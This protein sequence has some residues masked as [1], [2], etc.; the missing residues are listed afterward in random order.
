M[1]S[2]NAQSMKLPGFRYMGFDI[3]GMELSE[4]LVDDLG[5]SEPAYKLAPKSAPLSWK[6]GL[7]MVGRD[8][9]MGSDDAEALPSP[10]KK[11][12]RMVYSN[13]QERKVEGT[14]HK[15]GVLFLPRNQ[16]PKGM[17]QPKDEGYVLARYFKDIEGFDEKDDDWVIKPSYQ[18]E[19][20]LVWVPKGGGSFVVPTMD[21][22]YNPVTG[23]P[24]ETVENRKEA[25]KRWEKAG[26]SP[27]QAEK[28]ISRFY[29]SDSGTRAV[30]SWWSDDDVGPLCVDLS[31]VPWSWDSDVGSFPASW[32]AERSVAPKNPGYRMIT[33]D[34][35]ASFEADR[36]TL[37]TIREAVNK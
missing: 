27:E 1:S 31:G 36:K 21:G 17:L 24:F 10:I 28:E 37:E 11:A 6:V 29:R 33:E 12:G 5:T 8:L 9:E 26:L 4:A 34:E 22:S 13:C 16:A 14:W 15:D 20:T 3:P 7:Y 2:K 32:S 25:V 18:T 23:T 19:D 35:H 30:F